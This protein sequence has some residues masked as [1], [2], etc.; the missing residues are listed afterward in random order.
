MRDGHAADLRNKTQEA[1]Q[2]DDERKRLEREIE[3]LSE[4]SLNLTR[5]NESLE[6][7]VTEL[8]NETDSLN[9]RIRKRTD[10]LHQLEE[11]ARIYRKNLEAFD[12]PAQK[13]RTDILSDNVNS[14]RTVLQSIFGDEELLSELKD[15]V[16]IS[17][18]SSY[19]SSIAAA[20]AE[21]SKLQRVYADIVDTL[22][23]V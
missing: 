19:E 8:K 22:K 23:S 3:E 17:K 20:S 1:E 14:Y 10:E 11:C 21:L 15:E 4:R 13:R 18:K 6:K 5:E 9:K 12:A 2:L 7:N 16:V